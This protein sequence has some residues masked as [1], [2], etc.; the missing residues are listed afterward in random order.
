[1]EL[2]GLLGC[3]LN[4]GLLGDGLPVRPRGNGLA[5][6][7]KRRSLRWSGVHVNVVMLRLGFAF[8]DEAEHDGHWEVREVLEGFRYHLEQMVPLAL[9]EVLPPALY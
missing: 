9:V 1:M 4:F 7:Q 5:G 8:A 2:L 6:E 3:E